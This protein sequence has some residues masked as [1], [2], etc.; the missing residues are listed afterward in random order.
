MDVKTLSINSNAPLPEK[1]RRADIQK[2]DNGYDQ[3]N[4]KQNY[5]E[6]QTQAKI[7]VTLYEEIGRW[8]ENLATQLI[9]L[10]LGFHFRCLQPIQTH[11]M[12]HV[13]ELDLIFAANV[14]DFRHCLFR[15]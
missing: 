11:E 13:V 8:R 15:Q 5:S 14:R 7:H 9:C 10:N 4:R 1:Y 12:R 3:K 6:Q 2:N